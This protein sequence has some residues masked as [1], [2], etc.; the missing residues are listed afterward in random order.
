MKSL[1][2]DT[3][4]IISLTSNNL[5]WILP[6][7]K[8]RFKGQF[9]VTLHGKRELIDRPL[10]IKRF[11]FEALQ[12]LQYFKNGTFLLAKDKKNIHISKKII[13]FSK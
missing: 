3:G 9:Y 8:T 1:I 5:L 13:Q 6:N 2:F 7:L 12:T 10:K 4:S 11:S